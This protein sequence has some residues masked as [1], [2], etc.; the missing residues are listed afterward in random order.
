MNLLNLEE[1][2]QQLILLKQDHHKVG[3]ITGCF[4]ILHI[5]HVGLFKYA[6]ENVDLLV[7][8]LDSDI[9]INLS[10]GSGRPI[11]NLEQRYT[12]LEAIKYIDV[13]FCLENNYSFED[14]R[15]DAAHLKIY[16]SLKPDYLIT[17]STK[18]TFW[19]IKQKRIQAYGITLLKAP[20][21]VD[22]NFISSTSIADLIGQ[23]I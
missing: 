15:T 23:M 21:N 16:E 19:Q 14:S 20:D 12:L 11:H 17:N 2:T 5:G 4:D 7:V 8:G 22:V 1:A 3:L 9:A 13:V 10:K 6:K 18:D